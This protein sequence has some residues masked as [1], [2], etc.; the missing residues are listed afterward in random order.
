MIHGVAKSQTGLSNFRSVTQSNSNVLQ[1][2]IIEVH[3]GGA[4]AMD[5]QEGS[6]LGKIEGERRGD[7][8]E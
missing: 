2:I 5:I 4:K 8:R 3:H 7:N 6:T 1:I